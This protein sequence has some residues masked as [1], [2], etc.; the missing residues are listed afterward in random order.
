[1]RPVVLNEIKVLVLST[2]WG[3]RGVAAGSGVVLRLPKVIDLM[4]RLFDITLAVW[5][6]TVFS[7]P[8]AIIAALIRL[9]SKGPAMYWSDLNRNFAFVGAAPYWSG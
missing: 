9:S 6:L 7:I 8:M 5:L 2:D 4:K 3:K 1:M